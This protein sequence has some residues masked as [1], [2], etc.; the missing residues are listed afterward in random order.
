MDTQ[1]EKPIELPVA[2]LPA[3]E[4]EPILAPEPSLIPQQDPLPP[5]YSPSPSLTEPVLASPESVFETTPPVVSSSP[6]W[7][8]AH[9]VEFLIILLIAG[10]LG[11]G[12]HYRFG[13]AFWF[14]LWVR[15]VDRPM[16][17]D[18]SSEV[19]YQT[20]SLAGIKPRSAPYDL[21]IQAG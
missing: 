7:S 9:V 21:D 11:L 18:I 8:W 1:E 3:L 19:Q 13:F 17:F 6:S 4:P 10:M 2:P 5:T 14:L 20:V 15:L 12:W 16:P